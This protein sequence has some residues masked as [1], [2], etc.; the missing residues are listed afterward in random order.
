MLTQ[1]PVAEL[2][3]SSADIK[4]FLEGSYNFIPIL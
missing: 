3:S 4:Y 2:F 1:V